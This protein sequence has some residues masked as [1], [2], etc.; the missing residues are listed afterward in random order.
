MRAVPRTRLLIAL[1]L[2]AALA[3]QAPSK[4][5]ITHRDF[6]PWRTISSVTLSPDGRWLAYAY[7][8]QAG[9]GELVVR[10]LA[11]GREWRE[12]A[13][14]QPP[15]PI[16]PVDAEGPPPEPPAIRISFTSDSRW[17]V[18]STF[19][20]KEEMDK[21]R[22]ERRRAE[23]M[24]KNGLLILKLG[25]S[26]FTR[27][28]R[29]KNFQVPSRGGAWVAYHREAPPAPAANQ[30]RPA[31]EA[32]PGEDAE[33]EEDQ[34]ARRPAGGAAG[35]QAYGT[36]LVL[37]ELD[38]AENN[39]RVFPN[40]AEYSFAR[41][42]KTLVFAVNSRNEDEN[43]VYAFTP[44][45]E[46]QPAA[47]KSG[48]GK[49]SKIAWDRAQRR[50]AFFE[51]KRAVWVWD[52]GSAAAAEAVTN[53]T[54]GIPQGMEVSAN[55]TLQFSADAQRLF[56]P[57]A[58]PQEERREGEEAQQE[59]QDRVLMD[60]WHWKDDLVQ[61]MQRV[62]ASRERN[63]TYRGVWH[64][65][66][67][68]YV[69]LATPQMAEV[70]PART[71]LSAL[72]MDDR[73][74]RPMV[75]YDGNYQDVYALDT[76][77][78][79][80]KLLARQVRGGGGGGPGGMGGWQISPDGQ[81][82]FYFNDR[83]WWLVRLSD[84]AARNMT[85][86]LPVAFHREDH[87]TPS[88]PGPYGAAGWA[89]DSQS[90]FVYDRYD[91]WQI[92]AGGAE[93]RNLTAGAGRKAKIEFRI[94][95]IEPPDEEEEPGIDPQKPL[96]LRA[97]SEETRET[98]FFRVPAGGGEPQRLLWGPKNFRYV[99][100][101][102]DAD[103]LAITAQRFDEYP[104]VHIT[105]SSFASPRRATDGGA[106]MQPF[107]WGSAELIRYKNADGVPLQAA[108]Y[109]PANFDPKKKYPLMVYIYEKLSQNVHNFVHPRPGHN[110]NFSQYVSDGYVVLT[111]DIV[112]VTGQ[113]GQS[114]LKCV[115]A[116]VQAV[117]SMGFIDP[118]RIGI[119]GHSWGGYQVAYMVT[120][121]TRFRAA[122]AGAPVGN[123]TSAYSGIR[124]GSG[125]PR[126]FQ[127][128]KTQSRIG[129]PL[130]EDPLKYIEN[131]PVFHIRRVTTPLLILHDD[132]DDAVPWYQGIELF[133]A[134][135]RNG[136]EAYLLN[137]NGELHGLRRRHNQMDYA[138][139]MKQF[140]DHFLKDAPKPEWMEKGVP[141]LD[142]E[143]EKERFR[144]AAGLE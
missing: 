43:G 15:P 94:Q 76:R 110:F 31:A 77:T 4:R 125:L 128:E 1:C 13:G 32:K 136:K 108:L 5:P 91:V 133:L 83:H 12:N 87:D 11:T 36:D 6:D 61:P 69:Q 129:R 57:V 50:L 14:E 9:D 143:K 53:Q 8:P 90:F 54:P 58:P 99:T 142:R 10:E 70:T 131:S 138:I 27:I 38:R 124:W 78:G 100:R 33:D 37:R 114:A 3:A 59:A 96:T 106:Q 55:G 112:Y 102:R 48:K 20:R 45:A 52:R 35:R 122:E 51:E 71:G 41:D 88:E 85:G 44:G 118:D 23:D 29:V 89:K 64:F 56:V 28:D 117:E 46:G 7:M 68:R 17:L 141:Y 86:A 113:P 123:M 73:A 144:K 16:A 127:Y 115:L 120:Q 103:V 92:F 67:K 39:E 79:S 34:Q 82:A 25:T 42:G 75:D 47:L 22:K 140:F 130:Y 121:T 126:Q 104:D 2:A 19:P 105:N 93:P 30:A 132:Q 107:L 134:L 81:H 40:V 80:R 21:A 139:R 116:A 49:Y 135:R 95:R 72:G 109:K 62:R 97:E 98:G 63:R 18:A 84:G 74:Y 60:L 24:P 66:E 101:A 137:Y 65:D 119:A 26:G 111:P